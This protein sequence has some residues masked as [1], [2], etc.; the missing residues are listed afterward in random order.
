[1]KKAK[2][3]S[4]SKLA[5]H[6]GKPVRKQGLPLE[7]PGAYFYGKEES[8]L[9]NR[10]LRAQSPFRY[11]GF[12]L[13]HMADKFEKEFARFIGMP[14][15]LGVNS[16]TA[17]LTVG[18]MALGVGPGDE[19]IVP[20]YL[21]VSTA[22]AVV[23]LGAIPVLGDIDQSF[24]LDPKDVARKINGR[25]RAVIMVH[26]NGSTGNAAK[27]AALCRKRKVGFLE[28]VA[29]AAGATVKGKK[30]G[31]FGDISTYSFQLNKTMTMG[32]GGAVC[33]RTRE[34]YNR[35][36]AAHDLGYARNSSGRLEINDLSAATW[37][38]GSRMNEISAALGLAQL[39]KLPKI[40]AAM[41]ERKNKLK[42]MLS[43][44]P[45]LQ[46][47]NLDDTKGDAGSFL[48]TVFPNQKLAQTYVNALRAEGI[49][50]V[51]GGGSN[52]LVGEWG[53]HIYYNIPAL[54][55]RLS[56]SGGNNPWKDPRNRTSSKRRYNKGTL[57]QCDNLVNRSIQL[58]I[59]PILTNKDLKDI[60]DAYHKVAAAYP[61]K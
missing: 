38:N 41:R 52:V 29:Q 18:L 30:L 24:C 61:L 51:P 21:W 31:S 3:S 54:V 12:D 36:F 37:G 55:N 32:E 13:Q 8:T 22:T 42:K 1:M 2:N 26:M 5:I 43:D 59:P 35:A 27:I 56:V 28:D 58:C 48:L 4:A 40:C 23:R 50:P 19:V 20:G 53:L 44:I 49:A 7:F 25:T 47:R 15:A 33:C 11:Y 17:A 45:G 6:G 14:F 9:V 57:P 60:S 16:G 34:L 39:K 10:V 46:F